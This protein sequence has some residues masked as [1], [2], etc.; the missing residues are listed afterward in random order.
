MEVM[1]RLE[2]A[3]VRKYVKRNIS[4][5]NE[6]FNSEDNPH[7]VIFT[8]EYLMIFIKKYGQKKRLKE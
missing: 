6:F 2:K 1:Q 5:V 3:D 4:I 7:Y 8:G